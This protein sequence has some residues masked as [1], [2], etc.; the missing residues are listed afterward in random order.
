MKARHQLHFSLHQHPNNLTLFVTLTEEGQSPDGGIVERQLKSVEKLITSQSVSI[1]ILQN[2]NPAESVD[3][4]TESLLDEPAFT[5]AGPSEQNDNGQGHDHDAAELGHGTQEVIF[6]V[7]DDHDT[8]SQGS[9]SNTGLIPSIFEDAMK[10]VPIV[11]NFHGGSPQLDCLAD[12]YSMLDKRGVANTLFDDI[13][14]WA[15]L[16]GPS[17]G[18]NPPMKRKVVIDKVFR[19]VRGENYKQYMAPHQKIV[20]LSTGRHVAV[21]YFPLE[22]MIK[23]LLCNSTLMKADHLLLDDRNYVNNNPDQMDLSLGDVDSGSWW[24]TDT[25]TECIDSPS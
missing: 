6:D 24:K 13:V 19:H 11:K 10:N 17:F 9:Q 7:D 2:D 20:K 14:Q 5:T 12:L 18:R 16:N 1:E 21:T 4:Y 25:E 3:A 22:N 15:W 23:D 8:E